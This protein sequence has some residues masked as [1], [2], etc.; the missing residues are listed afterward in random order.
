MAITYTQPTM[1]SMSSRMNVSNLRYRL[2][3]LP[4]RPEL[5]RKGLSMSKIVSRMSY[6]AMVPDV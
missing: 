1:N 4:I 5:M 2:P 6:P 3:L